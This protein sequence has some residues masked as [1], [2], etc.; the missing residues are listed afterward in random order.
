MRLWPSSTPALLLGAVTLLIVRN[1]EAQ[2]ATE[3][4]HEHHQEQPSNPNA[5]STPASTPSTSPNA[6][7][8]PVAAVS[9]TVPVSAAPSAG[10]VLPPASGAEKKVTVGPTAPASPSEKP[11]PSQSAEPAKPAD[12]AVVNPTEPST[13]LEGQQP[14]PLKGKWSPQLYGYLEADIVRDSTQGLNISPGYSLVA[15]PGTIRGD[16]GQTA[17]DIRNTRFGFKLA[18]PEYNGIKGSGILEF[19]LW[20]N[21]PLPAPQYPSSTGVTE[22]QYYINQLVRIRHAAIKIEDPYVDVVAGLTWNLFQWDLKFVPIS[23]NTYPWIGGALTRA[24]QVRFSH[25]FKS[26]PINVEIAAAVSKPP[27]RAA[28]LPEGQAGI[29]LEINDWK[30]VASFPVFSFPIKAQLAISGVAR[31]FELPEHVPV[32]T[33]TRKTSGQGLALDVRLPLFGGTPKDRR[34]A[35]NIYANYVTGKGIGDLI[36]VNGGANVNPVTAPAPVGT[37][38]T[39]AQNIDNG[40]VAWDTVNLKYQPIQWTAYVFGAQYHDPISGKFWVSGNYGAAKSNNLKSLFPALAGAGVV[41][42]AGIV[43]KY[44]YWDVNAAYEIT[45]PVRVGA[46]YA[47]YK[48]TYGDDKVATDKRVQLSAYYTFY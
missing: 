14:E 32:P 25:L 34:N 40:L 46:S 48:N 24:E 27:Q 7:A 17:L 23:I 41:G 3:A 22:Q 42:P 19:D 8:E 2:Q 4:T 31:A 47:V 43:P 15:R 44:S 26:D 11:Q 6:P 45:V 39:Y 30:G 5:E 28:D 13:F 18:S 21:Q 38:A 10:A 16:H 9:A 35:A 36:T 37:T 12:A 20:G 1:V 29:R 33:S